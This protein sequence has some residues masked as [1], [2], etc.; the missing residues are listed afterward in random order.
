M[1]KNF[2]GRYRLG[3]VTL[4]LWKKR[5]SAFSQLYSINLCA[6]K[7]F[8]LKTFCFVFA[9]FVGERGSDA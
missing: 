5:R 1:G 3:V 9:E 2:A 6:N 4:Y 8:F 7:G